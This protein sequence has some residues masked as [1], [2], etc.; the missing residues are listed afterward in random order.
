MKRQ[1]IDHAALCY[2]DTLLVAD[3]QHLHDP[4]DAVL[5]LTDVQAREG[6]TLARF[7]HWCENWKEGLKRA[8]PRIGADGKPRDGLWTDAWG[9]PVRRGSE[10]PTDSCGHC[11][12]GKIDE[13]DDGEQRKLSLDEKL[14]I[15]QQRNKAIQAQWE[16]M[17][18]NPTVNAIQ[19]EALRDRLERLGKAEHQARA[20]L[21]I[22]NGKRLVRYQA[23]EPSGGQP[24]NRRASP[25]VEFW[26]EVAAYDPLGIGNNVP[27]E[28]REKPLGKPAGNGFN[29]ARKTTRKSA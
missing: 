17:Q 26:E 25:V 23:F 7:C 22:A 20:N 12:I 19:R 6:F 18:R 10:N 15:A 5:I 8:E 9:R 14:Q 11:V 4:L 28:T 24:A 1:S 27:V 29:G 16:E 13:E 21:E 3:G 2:I